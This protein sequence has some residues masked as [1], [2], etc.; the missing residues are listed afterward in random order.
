MTDIPA[1]TSTTVSINV[2]DTFVGT[3]ETGGDHDWIEVDLVAGQKYTF[4]LDGHGASALED[5]Y[6]YLRDASGTVLVENDDGDGNRNSRIVF[7]ATKTGTYY[8]DAS[9]WDDDAHTYQYT[10]DYILSAQHFT[11]PPVYSYSQI[12]DQLV[13]GYWGGDWHHFDVAQGGTITV[14]ITALTADGQTLARAALKEWTDVIGVN[15]KEVATGGQIVFDDS[16]DGAFTNSSWTNHIISES[17]VNVSTKWLTDYGTKTD[18]YG[19][20]TYVHEIGHALGLG[21]GGNY[22]DTAT[23]PDDA[24]YS[25]DAW[26]TTVMSYFSQHDSTYFRAQGFS[27]DFALTPMSADI[28]AMQTLYGLSTTTRTGNTIYGYGN[29]SGNP[30]LDTA[31]NPHAA[32]TIVDSGGTDTLNY[33]MTTANELIDLNPLTFSNVAGDTGNV[34]IGFGTVIENA[35]SGSGN[36]IIIGN[37][38][39]N[40][41]NGGA[42]KDTV[43]YEAATAGVRVNLSLG[44][45]QQTGSAGADTLSNFENLTGS[46]F[47]DILTGKGNGIVKGGA[48][49]DVIHG[50]TGG[51]RLFGEAGNDTFIPGTGKDTIDG[52]SGWDTVDFGSSSAGVVADLSNQGTNSYAT[53]SSIEE[54]NG[55]R[56]DDRLSGTSSANT[57]AGRAG[58]DI[59]IGNG[60]NDTLDGGTGTNKMYGGTGS[61]VYRVHESTDRVYE[62]SGEG[63]DRVI[64]WIDYTLGANVE[65]LSLIGDGDMT[66]KGNALANLIIGGSGN[67][68]LYGL[69]GADKIVGNAGNDRLDGGAGNDRLVGGTGNDRYYVDSYSDKIVE[70]AGEGA[71]SVYSTANYK[72]NPNIE[73]LTQTGTADIWAYGNTSDNVLTGNS[74]ANKLYGMVGNDTLNGGNGNDWLEGGAG[75]DRM[76]GGSGSDIFVFRNGDFGGHTAGTAD[77]ITDFAQGEDHIRLNYVDANTTLTGVQ[78]FAFIGTAA[79]DGHAG[80]LRYEEISGSTYIS[81]DTNGDGIADFMVRLDGA[82]ALASNDFIL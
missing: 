33:S 1:D 7:T 51:D 13:K 75:Q 58:D 4:T 79:F 35:S 24:I 60:G 78:A 3:I 10:G 41:L 77:R 69:D 53:Y 21:H 74:G 30:V 29:T 15:F 9:A 48:G 19:L 28:L 55:S 22:N 34:S 14:N 70:N 57:L 50:S 73:T 5:P 65:N 56:Y 17:D 64:S 45:A 81:G 80:E 67:D 46:D 38:A 66:G 42:G 31:A 40:V 23:Y 82:H 71:D 39:D 62:N 49:D 27:E 59:L 68:T 36:D 61:D 2:G 20:Q 47:N 11:P 63:T 12:A 54:A 43:S 25:N 44:T 26:S 16:Q 6:L 72:L 18:S 8:L 37:A 76:T 32:Y 52:G